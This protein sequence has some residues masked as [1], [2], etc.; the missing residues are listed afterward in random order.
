MSLFRKK[1]I[2]AIQEDMASNPEHA[3]LKKVL[4]VKDLTF[5]GIAAVIGAGIFSTIGSA[6]YDGGPGVSLLFVITAIT[7]GFSALC[8]AEFASRVP[9]SGSAYTYAYTSFG[10]LIAWII[11]WSLILEYSIGNIMVAISWSSYFNNLLHGMGVHLPYWLTINYDSASEALAKVNEAIAAGSAVTPAMQ[12]IINGMQN[13]PLVAGHKLFIN[14]PAFVIVALITALA[15]IGIQESRKSA[16]AMV[17]FK[18]LVIGFVI[19]MGVQYINT[20]NWSP[21]LPN[22]FTGVLKG[23]SAVFYA[24]IGFDAI[25]TTAEECKDPQRDLPRGMIYSLL[26]CT[27]IYIVI[28][29]VLTGMVH[30][31]E[32]KV[33]DPLA[34]V[35]DKLG[36]KWIGYIISVSAVIATTSVLLVFQLGQPRIWMTMSRD[37]LLPKKFSKVHPKFKTPSFA[38]IVTGLIVAIPAL[39]LPSSLVTDLTSIGTLFAFI[40][41]CAGVLTLPKLKDN[42]QKFKMPY[43]NG[44]LIVPLMYIGFIFLFKDRF[45]EAFANF[46]N[47]THE[48][49]FFLIF[50]LLAA[51]ISILTFVKNFSLIPICGVLFCSYLMIE[52]PPVSWLWF[53]IWMA[54]GLLFYFTFS[55]KNSKLSHVNKQ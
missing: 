2:S 48:Q 25:S 16:N 29:L 51:V 39:F 46:S 47:M 11:G 32:L 43:V 10:E 19:V 34:Y 8:Y 38:T 49:L 28:A 33:D 35:F 17:I 41:V 22:E 12:E 42:K 21:F 1:S 50:A 54:A 53:S 26:I 27:A 18:L 6:A 45:T 23:V 40:I 9:A 30:Y 37:G 5:L 20:D 4:T 14:M 7:C 36:L 44:K 15:Y 55:Y 24:Y 13:A 52:I 3:S 31:S